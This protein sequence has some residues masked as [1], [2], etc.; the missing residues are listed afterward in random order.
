MRSRSFCLANTETKLLDV[1]SD[2]LIF[3]KPA[4]LIS[5]GK[6]RFINQTAYRLK[7]RSSEAVSADFQSSILCFPAGEIVIHSRRA[8]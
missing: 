7:R 5:V 6:G 1:H 8:K 2:N 3:M 4:A